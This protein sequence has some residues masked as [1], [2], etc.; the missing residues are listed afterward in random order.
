[1]LAAAGLIVG[2]ATSLIAY[3]KTQ[4]TK[5]ASELLKLDCVSPEWG[6]TTYE[7]DE[8]LPSPFR[9]EEEALIAEWERS[10][11]TAL[12]EGTGVVS[13]PEQDG[14]FMTS[15]KEG[16]SEYILVLAGATRARAT[17]TAVDAGGY[18]VQGVTS[19]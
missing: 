7:L 8:S 12:P 16:E 15:A 5:D 2:G 18:V 6:S 11:P 13:S 1:M 10:F 19:C 14:F 4:G 3:D 9:T 17:V